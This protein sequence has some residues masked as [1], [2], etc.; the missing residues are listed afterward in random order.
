M[1]VPKQPHYGESVNRGVNSPNI[2]FLRKAR[3]ID[4]A[5]A[6]MGSPCECSEECSALGQRQSSGYVRLLIIAVR[7]EASRCLRLRPDR[8]WRK[9]LLD[10]HPIGSGHQ[11]LISYIVLFVV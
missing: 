2:N 7:G 6:H 11:N 1:V 4:T 9:V 8:A 10:K 3:T 5:A